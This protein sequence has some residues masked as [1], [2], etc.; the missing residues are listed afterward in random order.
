M[1]RTTGRGF[2]LI[3]LMIV[4][5]IVGVLAAI[6]YTAYDAY[7]SQVRTNE[8]AA[9]PA[10]CPRTAQAER[11]AAAGTIA[12]TPPPALAQAADARCDSAT[13][14]IQDG[15]APLDIEIPATGGTAA[16]L[17]NTLPVRPGRTA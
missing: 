6:A 7:L 9:A 12:S 13:R 11:Y 10:D 16:F 5:A 14:R 3:E 15:L 8:S 17:H 1:R 4:C 2:S